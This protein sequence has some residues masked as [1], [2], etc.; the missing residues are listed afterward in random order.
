[1]MN[2]RLQ[3]QKPSKKIQNPNPKEEREK[4]VIVLSND[5][6]LLCI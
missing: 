3:P 4:E 6:L 5:E 1:M 2:R